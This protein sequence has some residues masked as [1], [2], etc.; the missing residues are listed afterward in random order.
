MTVPD[1]SNG[2]PVCF[3]SKKYL[4]LC[5]AKVYSSNA[6]ELQNSFNNIIS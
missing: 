5:S 4:Q 1:L 6:E 3:K 2:E